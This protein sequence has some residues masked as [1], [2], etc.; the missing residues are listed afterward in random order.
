MTKNIFITGGTSG[1]GKATAAL[2]ASHGHRVFITG[3]D[4][5][6]TKA[7]VEELNLSG[8]AITD[9]IDTTGVN[10]AVAKAVETLGGL[11][12][13]LNN[14]GLGIFDPLEEAKLEDWHY[15]VDVNVKGL[16]SVV[17]TTL[18][19]LI[20]SNGQMINLGS[21]A[22]HF[23]FP[24]SGVYCATKHAVFAISESLRTELSKKIR[25]T[26]ISPG[27]VNTPFV[28]QTKNEDLL[29]NLR[30]SFAAGMP[31]EWI[32]EQIVHAIEVPKG[33]NVSEIIM[34][35]FNP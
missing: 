5:A 23:V 9:V 31:V 20:K 15:M 25:V 6:K 35:P 30:P 10:N 7:L 13:V 18:P 11:D 8:Y 26:T 22:S 32:A 19:H 4:E 21:I 17:H 28:E 16:L 29:Q 2:A 1:I 33:V 27:S 24:N 34:R 14:A 3:R 12:V